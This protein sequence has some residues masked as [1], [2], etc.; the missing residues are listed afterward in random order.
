M[1]PP[2]PEPDIS[3]ADQQAAEALQRYEEMLRLELAPPCDHRPA[4][5]VKVRKDP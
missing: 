1:S 2:K 5:V 4:E 3:A